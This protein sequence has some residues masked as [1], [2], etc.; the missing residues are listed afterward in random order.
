MTRCPQFQVPAGTL[1]GGLG[2]SV[3]PSGSNSLRVTAEVGG[4]S[5]LLP[6][7]RGQGTSGQRMCEAGGCRDAGSRWGRPR[8][9]LTL[10]SHAVPGPPPRLRAPSGSR[11]RPDPSGSFRAVP[12]TSPLIPSPRRPSHS[13]AARQ[14]CL[15]CARVSLGSEVPY[16]PTRAPRPAQGALSREVATRGQRGRHALIPGNRPSSLFPPGF[17]IPPSPTP[18]L[19]KN[20]TNKANSR[21]E[22]VVRDWGRGDFLEPSAPS[23]L[24]H[25]QN[26]HLPETGGLHST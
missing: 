18:N 8:R 24:S 9:Q 10:Q 25:K 21:S 16:P 20:N 23:P 7:A 4:V 19:C 13:T 11:S 17:C 26:P 22:F 3:P 15:R 6:P 2:C 1:P 5:G 12:V 14:P